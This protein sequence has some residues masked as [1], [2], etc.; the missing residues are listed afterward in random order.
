MKKLF[1]GFI[2]CVVAFSLLDCGKKTINKNQYAAIDPFDYKLD[3]R[4]ASNGAV[5]KFK[6]VVKFGL[7]HEH[8][9]TFYSLD[10]L[11]TLDLTLGGSIS[12]PKPGQIVTIYYTATKK[13]IDTLVLDEIDETI[14]T[15]EGINLVKSSIFASGVDK[16]GY[17]E[18]DPF[19]YKM[20]AELAQLGDTRKYKSVM[21][22]S[23]QNA[24]TYYFSS[25]AGGTMLSMRA[26]QRFP[27]LTEGQ[28]VTVYFTATKGVV[29]SLSLDAIEF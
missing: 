7:R 25:P 4:K 26:A 24:I 29:D 22:F 14:T 11:T 17:K 1:L 10:G 12:E 16:A 21:L 9:L 3:E 5:R 2:I 18:I 15:E 20:E 8:A 28:G 23:A 13:I 19:D 27:V 6:S